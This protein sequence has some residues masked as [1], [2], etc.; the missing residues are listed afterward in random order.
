MVL[1]NA[2]VGESFA[3]LRDYAYRGLHRDVYRRRQEWFVSSGAVMWYLPAGSVP[4]LAECVARLEFLR[5]HGPT[6]YGFATGQRVEH[7]VMV[8]RAGD[9]PE[10]VALTGGAA[11]A[12]VVHLA[13]LEGRPVGAAR[14]VDDEGEVWTIAGSPPWLDEA[15]RTHARIGTVS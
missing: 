6:P 13:V 2:S 12:G 4:T 7:L 9:D 5:R 11:A 14:T 8:A 15:L 1:V 10:V 3:H